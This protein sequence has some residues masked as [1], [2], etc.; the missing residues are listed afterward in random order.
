MAVLETLR[1]LIPGAAGRALRRAERVEIAAVERAVPQDLQFFHKL[2]LSLDSQ[3]LRDPYKQHPWVFAV[4][5]S[6]ARN[7]AQAPWR[8]G[9]EQPDGSLADLP[10][11]PL[12]DL[13]NAPNRAMTGTMMHALTS[14][15]LDLLGEAFWVLDRTSE[16]E[17]P[18][19]IFP[20]PGGHAWQPGPL[21]EDK[22]PVGWVYTDSN[23]QRIPYLNEQLVYFRTPNPTSP[24]RGCPPLSAAFTTLTSDFLADEYNK[25]FFENGGDPGGVLKYTDNLTDSEFKTIRQRWE[26]RHQGASKAHRVGVL[27]GG[28]EWIPNTITQRDMEYLELRKWTRDVVCAVFGWPKWAVGAT[29]GINRAT[30]VEM[31]GMLWQE[32]IIPELNNR[33]LTINTQLVNRLAGLPGRA[34]G[35]FDLD[36]VP[37]LQELRLSRWETAKQMGDAGVS[38]EEINRI[39]DLGVKPQPGWSEVWRSI[40]VQ[41]TAFAL[42][43]IDVEEP[44]AP[45]GPAPEPVAPDDDEAPDVEPPEAVDDEAELAF[46]ANERT[47]RDRARLSVEWIKTVTTPSERF[48]MRTL[49]PYLASYG[50]A[51]VARFNAWHAGR[52]LEATGAVTKQQLT[53]EAIESILNERGVWDVK[54]RAEAARIYSVAG[55]LSLAFTTGELGP[56]SEMD[57]LSPRVSRFIGERSRKIVGINDTLR[58]ATRDA[59]Q[60]SFA[61]GESV[62]EIRLRLG[63]LSAQF[64]DPAR[65]QRI[66]RTEVGTMANTVRGFQAEA[67]GINRWVW[68]TSGDEEVR[69]SH[70]AAEADS[71]AENGVVVG[72]AF[73]NGL[74][75]P[76]DPTAPPGEV[77]N[78]RCTT[79]LLPT[80]PNPLTGEVIPPE[81]AQQVQDRPN[82]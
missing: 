3:E 73:A 21:G 38:L 67:N 64:A 62:G 61:L 16:T 25:Q 26:D 77:I 27:E 53:A 58:R 39:L 13:L 72:T 65:A 66:A 33:A 76:H 36:D 54:L 69:L 71:V 7:F 48:A 23:G 19:A 57:I 68:V 28:A 42:N 11:S 41:P 50:R 45:A 74:V 8:I 47:R 80:T 2:G 32:T 59:L 17:I 78:C 60:E 82:A 49:R 9:I 20:L 22:I 5:S 10:S 30:A 6:R 40:T 46:K 70:V 56:G 43:P 24:L 18:K 44:Q 4:V 34:V 1:A 14:L 15:W 12:L 75:R 52:E 35:F 29:D 79:S 81:I 55:Q 63:T 37:A 31:R 51:Q